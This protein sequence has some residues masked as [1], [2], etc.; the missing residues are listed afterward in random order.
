MKFV[1]NVTKL[2]LFILSLIFLGCSQ[3]IENSGSSRLVLQMPEGLEKAAAESIGVLSANACFAVSIYADDIRPIKPGECDGAY[4]EFAG[5]VWSGQQIEMQLG[6][7]NNRTIEIFYIVSENGC[8]EFDPNEGLG[9]VFGS[10]RVYRISSHSGVDFDKTEM[11]VEVKVQWPSNANKISTLFSTP[12]S[13][14]I[15]DAPVM[16]M[17]RRDAGVVL[18]AAAGR[19]SDNNSFMRVRVKD[20]GLS[21]LSQT[22]WGNRLIPVRIGVKE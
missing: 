19:T 4:G 13:C 21:S 11:T 10:N 9:K 17:A 20:R 3:G 14:S 12:S 5:L 2:K 15:D 6:R 22:Q 8:A 1:H 7:G 16:K 18:G